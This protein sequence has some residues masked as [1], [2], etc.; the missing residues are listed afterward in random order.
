MNITKTS[1]KRPTL[2][3]VLFTILIGMGMFS[4]SKLNYELLPDMSFP[5]LTVTTTYPGAAPYEVE[6]SVTKEIED[7]VSTLEGLKRVNSTSMESVSIVT[8]EMQQGVDEDQALQEAQRKVNAIINDLPEDAE[9]PSLGKFDIN[10]LPIMNL[11]VAADLPGTELYD[12]VDKTIQP[13]LAKI[14][15]VA[16]V[17]ILGGQ[18]R[19]IR[20][21]LNEDQLETYGLSILQVSQA[22]QNANIDFPAGKVKNGET[23]TLLRLSGKYKNLDQM[24]KLVL[25]SDENGSVVRLEDV[26][27]VH[28]TQK[29]AEIITRVNG[30]SAIGLNIQKQGDANAVEVSEQ[31]RELM[32]QLEKDYEAQ[33]LKFSIASD[34]SEFTL[35]AADAV[36]HDLIFA[37]ILVALVMLLF[38][39]SLRNA[40]IVMLAVPASIIST[41]T[42]MML[43]GFSLNLMTLL[44]LSLVVGILVDDAIVV[45]EN[46]YRHME[47]GKNKFQAAY[48]GIREIGVTVISITLVIVAVFL[49][50]SLTGGLIGNIMRQFSI[51]VAVSTLLSLLVAFTMI[52]LLASRF[53][54]VSN[55]KS[56]GLIGK[57]ITWFEGLIEG[58]ETSMTNA[59]KWSFNHKI[60]VLFVTVVL[61]FASFTLVGFGF[62]GSEFVSSGD[63][64]EFK[65]EVELP[66][67][68]SLRQTNL[69]TQ[70]VEQFI[71]KY[72]EVD[73]I[74]ST[75]G[76][77]SGQMST[78]ATPYMAELNV[79]LVDKDKRSVST[80]VFSRKLQIALQENIVGAKF[81]ATP[82]SMVGGSTDAPIQVILSG[83]NLDSVIAISEQVKKLVSEVDGTAEV[84]SSMESGSPEIQVE[85][86]RDKMARLGLSLEMVGGTMRTAFNGVEES[87]YRDGDNEYDINILLDEFDRE[88]T[89]D[90]AQLSMINT[91]GERVRLDQIADIQEGS[92]PTELNRRDK[93][94]TVTIS[95]QVI[96]RPVGTVGEEITTKMATL[97]LPSGVSYNMGGDL[98]NQGEAFGSLGAA[99]LASLIIVYLIMVA[100][101]DSYVY[102]LV[103]MFSLPLAVIGALL[104]LALS[105]SALS[106]FSI[107]G[108]IMLI[109]LVAKNAILV[110]DFTNQL[111]SAGLSVKEALVKA[112]QVRIRPILMT[113]L[114]MVIGMMPIALASGAG[115]EWK[116][117]LAWVLIGGLTSSMFLTLVVVPVIYYIFDRI[118]AKF[119]L[120]KETK[121]ELLETPKEEL[122]T[123]VTETLDNLNAQEAI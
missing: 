99:L 101:Y 123:E 41:F 34:S 77:S 52:P 111:K 86:N 40:V 114:A 90:V 115:A 65:M 70:K 32:A 100:L 44:A 7:A 19:E 1:I 80:E 43:L 105:K 88:Q 117:G 119:G 4:Y 9:Q 23:Q 42:V 20:V 109:G 81:K 63:R 108:M 50:L 78:N 92:S 110:V 75:V 64:G 57:F 59:L 6:N 106:I 15:G 97:D 68:A 28:D 29:E 94:P 5:V 31:A 82:V 61:F 53:S 51:T 84:E 48:D 8:V 76:Q 25:S 26:A 49:P 118:L 56:K 83:T 13:Q 22:I 72:P 18:P 46:I 3:V 62:I 16:Q 85:M 21:N 47:M 98:E 96:G 27:E 39:H 73:R 30:E 71:N 45:I 36:I 58:F 60:I 38:L 35:E 79:Q 74:S 17:D 87:K 95:A 14:Q 93:V 24:R 69:L 102:P 107:L 37:V 120:D 33:N 116:N 104:A 89:E 103:V 2:V 55:L 11:G 122:N 66:K 12:L 113:T 91:D 54:K 67:K 112:T 10:D 121:I